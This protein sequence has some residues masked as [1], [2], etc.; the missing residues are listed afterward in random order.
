MEDQAIQCETQSWEVPLP[1]T[2]IRLDSFARQCLPQLSR[3]EIAKAIGERLFFINGKVGNKGDRLS[4]GDVL[5][6]N[7]PKQWLSV[8]IGKPPVSSSLPRRKPPLIGFDLSSVGAGSRSNISRW[9]GEKPRP[10][11]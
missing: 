7:G 3:R 2:D 4:G 1:L 11:D 10:K 8:S 9:C 5:I 6:F